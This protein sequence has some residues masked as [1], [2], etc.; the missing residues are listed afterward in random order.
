[1]TDKSRLANLRSA[2]IQYNQGQVTGVIPVM[3]AEYRKRWRPYIEQHDEFNKLFQKMENSNAN[4]P[5]GYM[6]NYYFRNFE[7]PTTPFYDGRWSFDEQ[8]YHLLTEQEMM[9]LEQRFKVDGIATEVKQ[10]VQEIRDYVSG[11]LAKNASIRHLKGMEEFYSELVTIRD[12]PWYYSVDLTN[13]MRPKV[14]FI[15]VEAHVGLG[16][17]TPFHRELYIKL[18]PAYETFNI[19]ETKLKRLK[20]VLDSVSSDLAFSEFRGGTTEELIPTHPPKA[21]I[22]HEG[23][24]EALAK[25]KNFLDALGVEY[26][27]AEGE[28]SDGRSVEGQVKWTSQLADFT[29]IL[30]TKGKAINKVTG[31]AYMGMNVADELGRAREVFNNRIILLL[32]IGVEPH[33]DISEIVHERFA[34]QSMDKA[35]IKVA[36]E[37]TGWGLIRALVEERK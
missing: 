5:H 27:M 8:S 13:A 31:K 28:P 36:R 10:D 19:L 34:P 6:T 37:L 23:K 29:I 26:L 14:E 30:A 11:V 3:L 18:Q 20:T 22:A 25:L 24:T 4:Y 32:Q 7:H 9:D 1:M 2:L 16:L 15:T 35:F 12:D 17:K 33:T 21:F